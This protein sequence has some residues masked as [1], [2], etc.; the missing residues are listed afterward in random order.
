MAFKWRMLKILPTRTKY[1]NMK[2]QF[3]QGSK[4]MYSMAEID[5]PK[6]KIEQLKDLFH[7]R[8]EANDYISI[9]NAVVIMKEIGFTIDEQKKLEIM[10]YMDLNYMRFDG[11][12]KMFNF[13]N[14]SQNLE[15][16][17]EQQSSDYAD[18]FVAVGGS[19]DL[20][21]VVDIQRIKDIFQN[22][23]LEVSVDSL[24]EKNDLKGTE[25]VDFNTFC[26][27]FSD[28]SVE[29]SKSLFTLINVSG[30]FF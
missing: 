2:R 3:S 16:T 5:I 22:F 8:K 10:N 1:N 26:K 11:I 6:E 7:K 4:R 23:H 20:S 17:S 25:Q 27:L 15:R 21:D 24:L 19:A 29:E 30:V 18:A 12:K 13:L 14:N 9:Y 28:T